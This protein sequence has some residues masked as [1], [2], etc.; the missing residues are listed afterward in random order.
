MNC[1]EIRPLLSSYIDGEATPEE[2][3]R[4][5]RHLLRCQDCHQALA[6]YRAIGSDISA[7]A[8]PVPPAS[9]RRDVW[10]A[11]EARESG[12]RVFGNPPAG[13][14]K[15][16]IVSLPR[17]QSRSGAAAIF[18]SM[19]NGWA[20]ALP[21]ALLVGGL[22]LV[23]A[24]LML[25]GTIA[26]AAAELVER[27][28]LSDYSKPIH[29]KFNERVIGGDAEKYTY[30][31][32]MEGTTPF[33]E[34]VIAKYESTGSNS[35]QLELK[36]QTSWVAGATYEVHV[37]CRKI[38]TGVADEVMQNAPLTFTFSAAAHTPT[39]TNTATSSP[40]VHT[41]IPT[42]TLVPE[43]PIF[44]PEPTAIALASPPAAKTPSVPTRTQARALATVITTVTAGVTTPT[45]PK[46]SATVTV[47]AKPTNT[48][49]AV[50]PIITPSISVPTKT[51]TTVLIGRKLKHRVALALWYHYGTGCEANASCFAYIF[52]WRQA[53]TCSR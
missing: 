51:V 9:L 43:P 49:V 23:M 48:V 8:L 5:E 18:T 30:V 15:T 6:E 50:T 16:Q 32:R 42:N 26:T 19:G 7:L 22:L 13:S 47:P 1:T 44:T 36:P 14:R 25:R 46:G 52:V 53:V 45:V 38:R 12:K 39:A 20:K 24:V 29:V 33:T 31:R 34:T 37:D 28:P 21:A 4:V 41:P 11:I 27:E 10:K 2:R 3:T 17:A 40:T 35:G